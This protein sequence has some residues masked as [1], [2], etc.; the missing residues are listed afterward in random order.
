[1]SSITRITNRSRFASVLVA[2]FI[3][4]AA[5]PAAAS[6]HTTWFGSS[7]DHSPANAG[8]TCAE[9]GVM[10]DALCTHVGSYYPGFSGRA[11]ATRNGTIT[12]IKLRAEGPTTM[13]IRVVAV[14]NVSSNH[15]S[16]QAK[17]IVKGPQLHP[18]GT[19][20]VETF[21]VHL[22][23]KK[24]EEIAIDSTSNTAEYCSDSTPGQLLF[25]PILG[26]GQNFRSSNGVD[27][28]LLLVQAV[29]KF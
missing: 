10:G 25:D 13:R 14:R 20:D 17:T 19:G 29:V 22:K 9:D 8:S 23:V 15:K 7:L 4:V 5:L 2:G 18:V 3:A 11:T 28:C 27:G 21:P 24:G 12:E 26:L 1:M 6:A 16:G